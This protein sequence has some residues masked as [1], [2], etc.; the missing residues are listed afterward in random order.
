M[1]DEVE[2][3]I[4]KLALKAPQILTIIDN[5]EVGLSQVNRTAS[6]CKEASEA[7]SELKL[8]FIDGDMKE[9]RDKVPAYPCYF[10]PEID[11]ILLLEDQYGIDQAD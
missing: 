3:I 2:R 1:A 11:T 9:H 4:W 6:T 8:D 7:L 5:I 10:N